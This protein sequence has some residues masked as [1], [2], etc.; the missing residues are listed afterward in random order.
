MMSSTARAKII[1]E[2]ISSFVLSPHG[3]SV[4][5]SEILKATFGSDLNGRGICDTFVPV[6]V[7]NQSYSEG[8]L[9]LETIAAL[10]ESDPSLSSAFV[11]SKLE[12]AGESG[13][14]VLS[15]L[16]KVIPPTVG[17]ND[18]LP[19][20]YFAQKLRKDLML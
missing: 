15:A 3:V 7:N 9:G 6:G 18:V 4:L 2:A 12:I 17:M 8:L 16:K 20:K 13:F 5:R 1:R 14:Q 11:F 19:N 10:I